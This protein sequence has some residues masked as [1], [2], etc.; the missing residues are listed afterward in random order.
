MLFSNSEDKL[1]MDIVFDDTPLEVV[2]CITFL[3]ITVDNKLSWIYHIDHTCKII[4]RNIG[5]IN[6]LKFHFPTSSLLMLYSSLILPY[7]NYGILAMGNTQQTL[8]NTFLLQK[9]SLRIIYNSALLFFLL[10][11]HFIYFHF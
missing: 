9:K 8:F 4:S 2:S 1:P 7:L 3:G 11:F 10:I 6:K 5:I